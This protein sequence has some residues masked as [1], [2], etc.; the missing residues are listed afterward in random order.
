MSDE[1]YKRIGPVE[2]RLVEELAE[3][4]HA[5]SK[6]IRF[7][8]NDWHPET[9]DTNKVNTAGEMQDVIATWNELAMREGLQRIEWAGE[10][11]VQPQ[12]E[13]QKCDVHPNEP[14]EHLV[15]CMKC[16]EILR[17]KREPPQAPATERTERFPPVECF[18]KCHK[19][20]P[21]FYGH[22]TCCMGQEK[23]PTGERE[24]G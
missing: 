8:W 5:V 18:C 12:G 20:N 17:Y 19:E 13:A 16:Q 14:V 2:T 23:P 11:P 10:A 4:I 3:V 1:R 9:K 6:A 21:N 24:G 22:G 7:G 15:A